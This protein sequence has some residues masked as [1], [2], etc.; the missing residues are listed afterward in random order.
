M[1]TSYDE[2][3][4]CRRCQELGVIVST[5]NDRRGGKSV[6]VQCR[7]NR[8][9]WFNTNYAFDVR[10]DGTVPPAVINRPKSF[11]KVPDMTDTMRERVDRQLAWET[12]GGGEISGR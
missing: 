8:C 7:N 1:D 2:A 12:N 10:A 6:T 9:R 3:R 11:P 5:K 4:R